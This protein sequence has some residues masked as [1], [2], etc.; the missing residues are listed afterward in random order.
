MVTVFG[1]RGG[2]REPTPMTLP[3]S[4]WTHWGTGGPCGGA[5]I[6]ASKV[7]PIIQAN[8]NYSCHFDFSTL[9]QLFIRSHVPA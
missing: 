5:G 6:C 1:G 7:C 9:K 8:Y 4:I 3:F 2:W